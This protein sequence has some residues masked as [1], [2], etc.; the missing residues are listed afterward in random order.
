MNENFKTHNSQPHQHLHIQK[1]VPLLVEVFV[2]T[3]WPMK[4]SFYTR[5]SKR[6]NKSRC[7]VGEL[8]H[9]CFLFL[10]LTTHSHAGRH[11]LAEGPIQKRTLAG[12]AES[13]GQGWSCSVS[14]SCISGC[15]KA[16]KSVGRMPLPCLVTFIFAVLEL[17]NMYE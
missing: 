6:R 10:T 4:P 3:I 5:C 14:Q 2:N 1:K 7:V 13:D 9:S 12:F 11:S 15:S 17:Q 16:N 8:E